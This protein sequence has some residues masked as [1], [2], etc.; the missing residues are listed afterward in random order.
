[1]VPQVP[2]PL[3]YP[4]LSNVVMV[5]SC[6]YAAKT[7]LWSTSI[8]TVTVSASSKLS[9]TFSLGKAAGNSIF[10]D[11]LAENNQSI[12]S[13][14]SITSSIVRGCAHRQG[15]QDWQQQTQTYQSWAEGFQLLLVWRN[16]IFPAKSNT[17]F[18][19]LELWLD[20]LHSRTGQPATRC[21]CFMTVKAIKAIKGRCVRA[22]VNFCV[23][24]LDFFQH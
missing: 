9:V 13:A 24:P 20:S 15:T 14:K 6:C 21:S 7:S 8:A 16:K 23:E 18:G 22:M 2:L 1:M 4:L 10:T 5:R 3:W 12:K 17:H 11:L 19:F